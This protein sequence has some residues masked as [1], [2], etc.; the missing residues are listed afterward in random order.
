[1]KIKD[2]LIINQLNQMQINS[3]YNRIQITIIRILLDQQMISILIQ[4]RKM[5]AEARNE[6]IDHNK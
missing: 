1:M 6:S 4:P 3:Y 2:K 5:E